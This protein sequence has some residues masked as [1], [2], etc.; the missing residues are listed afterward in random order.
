MKHLIEALLLLSLVLTA[1]VMTLLSL[2]LPQRLGQRVRIT[3][4]LSLSEQIIMTSDLLKSRRR[5]STP[6]RGLTRFAD[7]FGLQTRKA[8]KSL[9]GDYAVEVRRLRR[10]R[11]PWM[12]RWSVVLAWGYA[13]W[14]VFRSPVDWAVSYVLKSLRGSSQ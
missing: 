9:A 4:R 7:L 12:A 14:Y 3:I 5:R 2:L 13:L 1:R 6:L 8:I 10:E 11:R